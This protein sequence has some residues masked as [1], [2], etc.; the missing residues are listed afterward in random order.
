MESLFGRGSLYAN[1]SKY[2]KS[3]EDLKAALRLD[4]DHKNCLD[5]TLKVLKIIAAGLLKTDKIDEA[6]KVCESVL[7]I[8]PENQKVLAM[9]KEL[10]SYLD[11]SSR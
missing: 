9:K 11:S 3:F 5:Y 8:V 4:P 1:D 10:L 6:L 7:E 2:S